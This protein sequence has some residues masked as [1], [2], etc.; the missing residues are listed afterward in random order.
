MQTNEA[1]K[2]WKELNIDRCEM[3]FSCGG[4]SM[5]DTN[6]TLYDK[7]DNEVESEELADY[8]ENQVYKEVEFYEV[9]DGHYMGEYGKVE[10]TLEEDDDEPYFSYD[11]QAMAEWEETFSETMYVELSEKESEVL[12]KVSNINGSIWDNEPNVNYK[13]DCV[14]TEEEEQTLNE[15]LERIGNL[16]D[17]FEVE[18]KG[19]ESEESRSFESDIELEEGKLLVQVS[20]RFYYTE[21]SND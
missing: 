1:I 3:E 17:E 5:N 13:E 21:E 14:I 6:F 11:K 9:S 4:D 16:S 10:I 7:E 12:N 2:L 8:F 15:L 18:G 19:E 20:A